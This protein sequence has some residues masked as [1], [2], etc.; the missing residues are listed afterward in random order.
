LDGIRDA[1]EQKGMELRTIVEPDYEELVDALARRSATGSR[2]T[3]IVCWNDMVAYQALSYC[4]RA[5]I[6]VPNDVAITGFDGIR[7][8]I[9]V[10]VSLTSV[11]A[12]WAQVASAAI[13]ALL[14]LSQGKE[15]PPETVLPV[16][17]IRGDTA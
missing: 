13:N 9:G 8:P 4:R 6:S 17:L 16:E 15:V 10:D 1:A 2:A 5:G 7:S 11:R 12:P 14:D 3:A